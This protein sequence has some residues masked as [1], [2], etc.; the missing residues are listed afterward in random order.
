MGA[1]FRCVACETIV[2]RTAHRRD[3]LT[4]TVSTL[5]YQR[6]TSK[7]PGMVQNRRHCLKRTAVTE[8]DQG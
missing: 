4:V 2:R 1:N 5:P 6:Y 8:T 3:W 7:N